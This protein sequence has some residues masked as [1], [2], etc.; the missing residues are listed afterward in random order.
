MDPIPDPTPVVKSLSW[1]DVQPV[2]N[3]DGVTLK[4]IINGT[5]LADDDTITVN[6][7]VNGVIEDT[8]TVS[9]G[10]EVIFDIGACNTDDEVTFEAILVADASVT[11][12]TSIYTVL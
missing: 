12:T 9:N 5:N 11:A 3:A 8:Q 4:N 6:V 10:D 2:L 7:L 1:E